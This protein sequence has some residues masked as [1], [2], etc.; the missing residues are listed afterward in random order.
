MRIDMSFSVWFIYLRAYGSYPLQGLFARLGNAF[1][2]IMLF[3]G[4]EL[5]KAVL[6]LF[7]FVTSIR[8]ASS[9]PA[10]QDIDLM[11][12]NVYRIG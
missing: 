5:Y 12:W 11:K 1:P 10:M 2:P 6:T 8:I 4:V 9:K 7:P 3:R